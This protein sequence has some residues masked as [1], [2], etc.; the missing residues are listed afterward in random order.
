MNKLKPSLG[1]RLYALLIGFLFAMRSLVT[2]ERATHAVGKT[3]FGKL[4]FEGEETT[5]LGLP[6]KSIDVHARFSNLNTEDDLGLDVR[7]MAISCINI[8][9]DLVM[10]TGPA[11][12]FWNAKTLLN[13]TLANGLGKYF[14]GRYYKRNPK[15]LNNL[16][17]AVVRAP[18]SYTALSYYSQIPI[19]V[20]TVDGTQLARFRFISHEDYEI[21]HL[22]EEVYWDIARNSLNKGAKDTTRNQLA[23]DCTIQKSLHLQVS[24]AVYNQVNCDPSLPWPIDSSPWIDLGTLTLLGVARF[25]M[26]PALPDRLPQWWSTLGCSKLSDINLMSE[27]RKSVYRKSQKARK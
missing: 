23:M 22:V 5:K 15:A 27:L 10:N 12:L 26:R 17:K 9:L 24:Y 2:R 16:K 3:V 6:N 14:L 4:N 18:K 1:L 8:R 13:F 11:L 7:G 25:S 19:S 20:T 21:D